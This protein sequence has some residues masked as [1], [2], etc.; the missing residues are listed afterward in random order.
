MSKMKLFYSAAEVAEI[1][2]V[3]LGQAYRLMRKWNEDLEQKHYLV[4]AGKIPISYFNEQ[5][6]GGCSDTVKDKEG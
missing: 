3:S 1:L 4:I 5:I 2:G 6:Y